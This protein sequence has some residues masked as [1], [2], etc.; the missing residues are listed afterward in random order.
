MSRC[1]TFWE[2]NIYSYFIAY[3]IGEKYKGGL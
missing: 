2:W 1:D 3:L